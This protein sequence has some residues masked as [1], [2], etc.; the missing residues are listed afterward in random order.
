ML[1]AN[2]ARALDPKT[3]GVHT[4]CSHSGASQLLTA[5]YATT[6]TQTKDPRTVKYEGPS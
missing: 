6:P 5:T 2:A 4:I 1:T 3:C